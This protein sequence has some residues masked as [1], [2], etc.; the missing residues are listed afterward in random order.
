MPATVWKGHLT[1]GLISI[2]VKLYRA[3]RPEKVSFRQLHAATG[4]RVRQTL[5]AEPTAEPERDIE[6]DEPEL[7]RSAAT[8]RAPQPE[9]FIATARGP[10]RNFADSVASAPPERDSRAREISRSEIAKGYEYA[11]D[12]YVMFTREELAAITPQ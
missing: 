10:A 3:A 5:V 12:S 8:R 7:S 6:P 4:T 1:F 2:P 11:P 9:P